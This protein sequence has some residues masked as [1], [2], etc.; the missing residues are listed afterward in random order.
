MTEPVK[1]DF[2]THWGFQ[3]YLSFGYLYLLLLGV[4][5]DSIFYGMVGVNI[6][7]YS[8]ILDVL[9]SPIVRLTDNLIFPGFIILMPAAGYFYIKLMIALEAKKRELKIKAAGP[10][11]VIPEPKTSQLTIRTLWFGF[12]CLIIFSAFI[13]HGVGAGFKQSQHLKE[14]TF[15]VDHQIEFQD[16][17]EQQVKVLGNNSEYVFYV[18]PG[19]QT[20]R[21]SPI[22]ETINAIRELSEQER[23]TINQ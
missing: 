9:L 18:Q 12:T 14:G 17:R 8:T 1:T 22:K 11:T 19:E 5:S 6:I 7:S 20:V 15:K 23:E 21:I 3:D 10:D 13:G 16:G 4:A 2:L